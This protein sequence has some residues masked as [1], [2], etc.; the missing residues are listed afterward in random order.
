[1]T[2]PAVSPNAIF[3]RP[4]IS[5]KLSALHP[6][7]EPGKEHRPIDDG[8]VVRHDGCRL[9]HKRRERHQR[10]ARRAQAE[11]K[12][13]EARR[14]SRAAD[15]PQEAR[16]GNEPDEHGEIDMHDQ[17]HAEEI[18]HRQPLVQLWRARKDQQDGEHA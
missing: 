9:A 10:G 4:S 18:G 3:E 5:V 13:G 11:R 6:R 17:R 1:M 2:G 7:F 8:D 15:G 12:P 14:A 16:Q